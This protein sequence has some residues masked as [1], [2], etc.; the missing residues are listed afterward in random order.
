MPVPGVCRHRLERALNAAYGDGL[1]SQRTFMYRIDR[2][3]GSRL[4]DPSELV[5]DLPVRA[6]EPG[7]ATVIGRAVDW[8]RQL[9]REAAAA[10]LPLLALDWSG[11]HETLLVGRHEECDVV[12][13]DRTVSRRHARLRFR[14]GG[15]IL[16][17]LGSTNGTTV[18]D[19]RVV[20]CRLQPG[21]QL[22]LGD[23]RLRVD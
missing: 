14:D 23:Q 5:G 13:G 19:V 3:L 22:T 1:L 17:D 4:V 7:L 18:N 21:D 15:W 11:G 8:A 20:R 6:P 2:L 12:L 16:Q 10:E 9:V